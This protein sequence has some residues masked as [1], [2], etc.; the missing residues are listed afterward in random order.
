[1]AR[2]ESLSVNKIDTSVVA[3]ETAEPAPNLAMR[4]DRRSFAPSTK[5]N[6]LA[7]LAE[8]CLAVAGSDRSVT[9]AEKIKCA[10]LQYLV[11]ERVALHKECESKEKGTRWQLES[12]TRA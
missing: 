8:C 12:H 7:L 4:H 10:R 9:S 3:A 5:I 2:I 6:I 1:M 11:E